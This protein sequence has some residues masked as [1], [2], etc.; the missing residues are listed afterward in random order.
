MLDKAQV[1]VHEQVES[2]YIGNWDSTIIDLTSQLILSSL[3]FER[4]IRQTLIWTAWPTKI[5]I[6]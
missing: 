5:L 4:K 3:V 1:Y 6:M 2:I